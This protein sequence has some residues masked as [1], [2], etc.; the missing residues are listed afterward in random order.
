MIVKK[1]EIIQ[2]HACSCSPNNN[3]LSPAKAYNVLISFS[4]KG[5][6]NGFFL[7]Y[8]VNQGLGSIISLA[9]L[10]MITKTLI[11]LDITEPEFGNIYCLIM[12]YLITIT[13]QCHILEHN[14]LIVKHTLFS[15]LL[16]CTD[17]Q[18]KP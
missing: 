2:E 3:I 9:Q 10:I 1:R 4:L 16:G 13:R 11:I 12:H 14:L 8:S 15:S 6:L 5:F 18:N 7:W 17:F